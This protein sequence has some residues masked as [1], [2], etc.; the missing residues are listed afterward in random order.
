M[1][2]H[3][4]DKKRDDVVIDIPGIPVIKI[5]KA[6]KGPN[7]LALPP[8]RKTPSKSRV[9][10][11]TGGEYTPSGLAVVGGGAK[12]K[13][14]AAFQAGTVQAQIEKGF[15][16]PVKGVKKATQPPKAITKGKKALPGAKKTA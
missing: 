9:V 16:Q 13:V 3:D 1:G 2:G 4:F 5:P 8:A 14:P 11:V 6:K 12:A 7:I 10:G 15:T